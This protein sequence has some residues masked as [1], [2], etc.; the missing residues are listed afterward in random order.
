MDNS[1]KRPDLRWRRA[2]EYR[3]LGR[4]N[5]ARSD[6]QQ[7]VKLAPGYL[8]AL[9]DLSRLQLTQG[10]RRAALR[11]I[12]RALALVAEESDRAP[13]RM[14]RAE[15]FS[16]TG[17]LEKALVDCDCALQHSS[18]TELDWYLTRSQI[19]CRLGRFREAVAGLQQG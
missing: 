7:A 6:L 9:T 13:L 2:T 1:G 3:A 15:I 5:A 11:T 19:Q 12:Q 18:G 8:P 4:L 14:V 10:N 16:A 17:D